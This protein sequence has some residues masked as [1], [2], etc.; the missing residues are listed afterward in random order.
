MRSPLV[1]GHEGPRH[2][3]LAVV[4]SSRKWMMA[5]LCLNMAGR[6]GAMH[7]EEYEGFDA[8]GAGSNNYPILVNGEKHH[9]MHY[10]GASPSACKEACVADSQCHGLVT[11]RTLLVGPSC[12]FRGGPG[13]MPERLSA[14]RR[15]H[16]GWGTLHILFGRH[17]EPP[18]TPPQPQ[19]PPPPLP[20]MAPPP[21]MPPSPPPPSPP[22]PSP[23]P[24]PSS[25]PPPPAPPQLPSLLVR[26]SDARLNIHLD[27]VL[28]GPLIRLGSALVGALGALGG[29]SVAEAASAAL[30][31]YAPDAAHRF[32][33][34]D[35]LALAVGMGAIALPPMLLL[36]I[37]ICRCRFCCCTPGDAGG[38]TLCGSDRPSDRFVLAKQTRNLY[39][40][41]VVSGEVS[42]SSP[43]RPPPTVSSPVKNGGAANGHE[44]DGSLGMALIEL[45]AALGLSPPRSPKPTAAHIERKR[46]FDRSRGRRAKSEPRED[47]EQ[48]QGS[49]RGKLLL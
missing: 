44:A 47:V 39:Y 36:V 23:S 24:P 21:P 5:L 2:A 49:G 10:E 7:W 29:D 38:A 30:R 11:S 33:E 19:L 35:S 14:I 43:T 17:H 26:L 18:E 40:Q 28:A 3:V 8:D 31:H 32:G 42:V 45:P 22:P 48:G 1:H 25:P 20:P 13:Q 12:Y 9:S 4:G 15:P 6:S 37:F 34:R 46:S 41:T 16:G 27:W